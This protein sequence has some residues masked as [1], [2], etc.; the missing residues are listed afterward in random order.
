MT[1]ECIR[2]AKAAQIAYRRVRHLQAACAT[3]KMHTSPMVVASAFLKS[4]DRT[5]LEEHAIRADAN[6][7]WVSD[8][9]HMDLFSIAEE[10]GTWATQCSRPAR[11]RA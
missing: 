7:R 6:V 11:R 5:V 4:W 8:I 9:E 2:S 10:I 1:V 3:L